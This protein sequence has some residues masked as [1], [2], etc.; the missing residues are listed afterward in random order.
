MQTI[1]IDTK[2]KQY[3]VHVG[4]NTYETALPLYNDRLTSADHVVV[5]VDCVVA[6]L[7]L[8][9]LLRPLQSIVKN[10]HVYELPAGE[11]CKSAE[12]FMQCHSFLLEIGCTRKSVIFA[13]GGGAC[14]DVVGFVAST[15]MRGI[16][17]YQCPTTILAHDSAVGG[18]TAINHPKGKNMVGTFYQPEA[19]LYDVSTLNTLPPREILSGMAEVI[20]HALISDNSWVEELFSL[21]SFTDISDQQYLSHL[22]KGI[23]V[24]AQIVEEDEFEQSVRKFLNLGHTFGH[25]IE[26]SAGYGK[27]TH[28]ESVAIG[29]VFALILSERIL[30]LKKGTARQLFDVL[31]RFGYS[32]EPVLQHES[33]V[34][35]GY[36]KRDKKASFGNLHF[37]LL[38]SIGEPVLRIASP[39]DIEWADTE[40]RKWCKEGNI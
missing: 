33:T 39:S 16:P 25:A 26:A 28:G 31:S 11:S 9:R 19:V 40:L 29:L 15:Y 20:K 18:K 36:M 35:L 34:L 27:I 22:V 13:L 5:F 17:F 10:V 37:V 2:E 24:K 8:E 3:D 12:T 38:E 1:S 23:R 7:H 30:S 6:N 21:N 32:F 4:S 14:G